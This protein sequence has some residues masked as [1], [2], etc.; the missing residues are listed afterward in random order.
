MELIHPENRSSF[1]RKSRSSV[2]RDAP[3]SLVQCW[4][5][6][7]MTHS[8]SFANPPLIPCR[9]IAF[10]IG[11]ILRFLDLRFERDRETASYVTRVHMVSRSRIRFCIL[12]EFWWRRTDLAWHRDTRIL[13]TTSADMVEHLSDNGGKSHY[14]IVAGIFATSGSLLGKL[15]G[16]VD[17]SSLVSWRQIRIILEIISIRCTWFNRVPFNEN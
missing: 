13:F 3:S 14:A 11:L 16:G 1:A 6:W 4:D 5:A 7:L 12:G 15:A 10:D 8:I 17:A 9:T 2:Q